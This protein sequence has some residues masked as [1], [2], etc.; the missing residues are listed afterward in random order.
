MRLVDA[1]NTYNPALLAL[2]QLGCE[3]RVIPSDDQNDIGL[4]SARLDGAEFV[5]GDPLALLGLV[6]LWQHRGVSWKR[7]DDEDLYDTLLEEAY[8]D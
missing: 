5:A 8:P 4:W 7:P 2:K 6:A 1:P 3:L